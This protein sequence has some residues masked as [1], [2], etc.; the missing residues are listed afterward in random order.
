[1]PAKRADVP[2]VQHRSPAEAV[3]HGKA[4]I[5]HLRDLRMR[6]ESEDVA[7]KQQAGRGEEVRSRTEIDDRGLQQGR[8]C[9]EGTQPGTEIR[10]VVEDTETS[11]NG[12]LRI[13]EDIVGE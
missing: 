2:D 11:A 7:G 13:S 1:M 12:G 8:L 10:T 6:I 9:V 4:K 3:L 5:H